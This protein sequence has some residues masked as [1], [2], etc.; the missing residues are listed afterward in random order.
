[1][2]V[3]SGLSTFTWSVTEYLEGEGD[4]VF[5]WP[6]GSSIGHEVTGATAA[7]VLR[8]SREVASRSGNC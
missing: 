4:L 1:M 5:S 6:K 3:H 8:N 2:G 7:T